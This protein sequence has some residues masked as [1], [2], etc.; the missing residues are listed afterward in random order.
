[1]S[2]E[3]N[4]KNA[5][6]FQANAEDVLKFQEKMKQVTKQVKALLKQKAKDSRLE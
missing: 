2:A 5:E 4:N 1:M 6:A 3:V